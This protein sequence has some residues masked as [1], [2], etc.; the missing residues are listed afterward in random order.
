MVL[1][2]VSFVFVP[3]VAPS[4]AAAEEV[5]ERELESPFSSPAEVPGL[6]SEP[7]MEPLKAPEVERG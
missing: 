4:A 2:A 1:G 6:S 7:F 3:L 5:A